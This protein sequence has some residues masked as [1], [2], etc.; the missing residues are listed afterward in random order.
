MRNVFLSVMQNTMG[1]VRTIH[2]FIEEF[3]CTLQRVSNKGY[4]SNCRTLGQYLLNYLRIWYLRAFVAWNWYMCRF[5]CAIKMYRIHVSVCKN[6]HSTWH[7]FHIDTP[8]LRRIP[9]NDCTRFDTEGN[10]GRKI[11]V[12]ILNVTKLPYP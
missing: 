2:V 11:R 1:S 4:L 5:K 9:S 6:A 7:Q 3:D 8:V 10:C 12:I